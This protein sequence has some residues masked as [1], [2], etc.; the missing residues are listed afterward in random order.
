MSMSKISDRDYLLKE[1]YR[2][3][4]NLNARF[5]LHE[6]FS[7][8]KYGWHR[9]V[10]DQF[11]I[12]PDAHIL[13]LGCGQG[14]LWV[15]N[16]GRI[17]ENWDI[18]L[19]DFSLGMLQEAQWNLHESHRCFKIT[20]FDAQ[21]VPFENESFDAV[22]AN[23]MLYHVPD[24]DKVF[25]EVHRVLRPNGRFY[26]STNGRTHLQELGELVRK[27]D[28]NAPR[29]DGGGVRSSE[30]FSL[31]NGFDQLSRWFSKVTKRRYEDALV[32][33]EAEPLIAWAKSWAKPVFVGEKLAE[34]IKFLER[35]LTSHGSIHVTKDPGI[36]EAY[37]DDST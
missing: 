9:W 27:F 22:I 35:E 21:W 18:T 1:Q 15:K 13:E 12:H 32:I 24:R 14:F 28:R 17:P 33:T 8:N 26:A 20:V 7:I 34:F 5:Q 11:D 6:R 31:E 30:K 19:S 3:A 16:I 25:S 36:F 4:S 10:F 2:N 23:H 29:D 37:R